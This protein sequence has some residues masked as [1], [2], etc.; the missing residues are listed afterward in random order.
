[1]KEQTDELLRNFE[2]MIVS[3]GGDRYENPDISDRQIGFEEKLLDYLLTDENF[4]NVYFEMKKRAMPFAMRTT[5]GKTHIGI[6][7]TDTDTEEDRNRRFW[8]MLNIDQQAIIHAMD[9]VPCLYE[10]WN[11][12]QLPKYDWRTYSLL[13]IGA[14]TGAGTNF[15]GQLFAESHWG[16]AIK[17]AVTWLDTDVEC[18]KYAQTQPYIHQCLTEDVFCLEENSYDVCFCSHTIEH[19][20]DPVVFVKQV[21]K[22]SKYFSLFYC[23]Y[24][25]TDPLH[26]HRT[27]TDEIIDACKPRYKKLIKS[28]SRWTDELYFICFVPEKDFL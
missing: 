9:C 5:K 23:P 8:D 22:I 21:N 3:G 14:R 24:N 19:L 6:Q 10:F 16:Y 1:V 7:L 26:G 2:N 13:D 12:L 20:E 17:F 25:E 15:L 27:I 4:K 11:I 28:Q 18:K